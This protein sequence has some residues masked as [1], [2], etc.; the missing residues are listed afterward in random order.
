MTLTCDHSFF[1]MT[2]QPLIK[3]VRRLIQTMTIV[4]APRGPPDDAHLCFL[5][6]RLRRGFSL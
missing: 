2:L 6:T 3:S 5:S 1:R 4:I